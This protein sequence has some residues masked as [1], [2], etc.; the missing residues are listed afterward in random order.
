[1]PKTPKK[2]LIVEDNPST[3]D[4]Y[5]FVLKN[6][7]YEVDVAS[8]G[9]ECL[10]KIEDNRPDLILMD[11]ILP[12]EDGKEIARMLRKEPETAD[13]PIIFTTNTLPVQEDKGYESFEIDGRMYRAFAKPVHIPKFLS[14]VRKE[15]NKAVHGG[16]A[17]PKLRVHPT[18]T[19]KKGK[20]K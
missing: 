16:K 5:Q 20:S 10:S 2:I 7:G 19:Y 1:M 12:D 9:E 11:V 17:T 6:A 15:Y 3:Q 18:K 14:A 8:S 4:V 13:I